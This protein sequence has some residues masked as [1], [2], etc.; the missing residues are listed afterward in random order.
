M[1][2]VAQRTLPV[3][4][5]IS[6]REF[7][8]GWPLTFSPDKRW[9]AYTVI[10][11]RSDQADDRSQSTAP[12]FA[13]GADIYLTN[14]AAREE[15]AVTG[16]RHGPRTAVILHSYLTAIEVGAHTCGSGTQ[17]VAI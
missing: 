5:A 11:G 16:G 9:L 13:K 15:V 10:R 2:V 12:W 4:D 7:A 14:L 1:L 6:A 8:P 3:E 17:M